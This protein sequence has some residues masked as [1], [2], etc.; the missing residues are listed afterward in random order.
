MGPCRHAPFKALYPTRA[1]IMLR[2]LVPALNEVIHAL[3]RLLEGWR[4]LGCEF[5][6]LENQ[7]KAP[8]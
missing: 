8:P 7:L 6:V 5:K 2:V 1:E 4:I 3:E